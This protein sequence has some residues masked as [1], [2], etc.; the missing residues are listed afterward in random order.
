V[1]S[2]ASIRPRALRERVAAEQPHRARV[3][4]DE[5]EQDPHRR[6]LAGAVRA[7][8]PVHV[9]GADGEVDAI[10]RQHIAVALHES[11]RDDRRRRT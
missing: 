5:P 9:A 4:A 2:A 10:Y 8:E 6:G 1:S 11:A 7:E 3:R